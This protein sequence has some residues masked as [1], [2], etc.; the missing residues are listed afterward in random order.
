[1]LNDRTPTLVDVVKAEQLIRPQLYSTSVRESAALSE[2]FGA[3]IFLKPEN[4]Q[5]TGSF[6]IRGA[7]NRVAELKREKASSVMTASAGN[8]GQG[9]GFAAGQYGLTATVIVPD[10]CSSAK[11]EALRRMNVDLRFSGTSFDDAQREVLKIAR[12]TGTPV[13]SPYDA[14]VVAG[15]GTVGYEFLKEAPDLDV[16]LVPVGAGGLLAGCS[17]AAKS[18]NS[19]VRVI[20]V[21]AA[22]SPSMV[23]ALDA[24]R[25]VDVPIGATLADG[26]EGNIEGGE[27]P[28][29]LI[30]RFADDVVLVQEESIAEAM[31]LLVREE[32]LIVEGAGAVGLAWLLEG[33][34]DVTGLRIGLVLSGGNVSFETLRSVLCS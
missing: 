24:G 34:L 12:S 22:Q 18:M 33:H 3:N 8:H 14:S 1:M 29:G 15:Q 4:L 17:L 7:L 30:Q 20:G 9:V 6:K 11:V 23:A 31:R 32:R 28:F 10:T 27:L 21:Q 16:L 19:N 13:V 2:R 26:L 5:R 25:I